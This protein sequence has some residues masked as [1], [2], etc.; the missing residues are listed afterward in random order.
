MIP[1]HTT[2]AQN[3]SCG[4]SVSSYFTSSPEEFTTKIV[5]WVSETPS[6]FLLKVGLGVGWYLIFLTVADIDFKREI[7]QNFIW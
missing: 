1:T 3:V 5:D 6:V 4:I 2:G 7:I